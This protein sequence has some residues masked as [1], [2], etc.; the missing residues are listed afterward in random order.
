MPRAHLSTEQADAIRALLARNDIH[1][2]LIAL[3]QAASGQKD[4]ALRNFAVNKLAGLSEITRSD[5]EDTQVLQELRVERSRIRKAL[6][7]ELDAHESPAPFPESEAFPPPQ[8]D[9]H[10]SD[11]RALLSAPAPAPAMPIFRCAGLSKRYRRRLRVDFRLPPVDLELRSGEIAAVVGFNGAGKTTLL[12]MIAGELAHDEGELWLG[13]RDDR[14]RKLENRVTFVSQT[15]VPWNGPL[16]A[17]LRRQA[18]FFGYNTIEE[19]DDSV[20]D[21]VRLLGMEERLDQRWSELST[22]YRMRAAIAVALVANPG[23]LVLDEPLA[24]LDTRSQQRLLQ[25]LRTRATQF[26]TAIIVSSQHIPEIESIADVVL[27]LTDR[28]AEVQRIEQLHARSGHIF[29]LDVVSPGEALFERLQALRAE[30]IVAH[31]IPGTSLVVVRFRK[32][33]TLAEAIDALRSIASTGIRDITGSTLA[34]QYAENEDADT[35][36]GDPSAVAAGESRYQAALASLRMLLALRTVLFVGFSFDDASFA[37]QLAWLEETF[38]GAAGPHYVLVREAE[39]DQLS[40][41]V[42]HLPVI[43][44]SYADHGAP[45]VAL[46]QRLAAARGDLGVAP[47]RA[48]A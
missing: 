43:P 8:H 38:Q 32:S 1:A 44:I 3:L 12:R 33:R 18:A 21:A 24:P 42:R 15:I 34:S 29:F 6:L 40:E 31:F 41:R 26:R 16:H 4:K 25:E 48:P 30:G 23:M 36:T 45:L 14:G 46:L 19:N 28:R 35:G 47:G 2:A 10:K 13:D 9:T 39:R 11:R 17:H 5:S 20:D 27:T 22:G 7:D 37:G